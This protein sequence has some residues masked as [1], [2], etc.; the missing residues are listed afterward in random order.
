MDNTDVV[1]KTKKKSTFDFTKYAREHKD[2]IYERQRTRYANNTEQRERKKAMM[3]VYS[4]KRREDGK[5][6]IE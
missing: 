6:S 5:K 4:K 3:R 1:V 2:I